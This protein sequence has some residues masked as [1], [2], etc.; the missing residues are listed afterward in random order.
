MHNC[1][2]C[3]NLVADGLKNC[4]HCNIEQ[5]PIIPNK[6][7]H[8]PNIKIYTT[9]N[10]PS[11]TLTEWLL[12]DKHQ[13]NSAILIIRAVFYIAL[14][15]LS[16]KLLTTSV[17]DMADSVWFL[18]AINTPFHEAGH[19]IFSPF[20]Q[21]IHSLGGTLGQI[22]M[23]FIC[24]ISLLKTNRDSFGASIALWWM[25]EN[26]LDISPYINDARALD[27]PLLG[28][29]VGHSSPYGFHDWEYL[30]TEANIIEYDTIIAKIAFFTGSIII[31]LALFW[32]GLILFKHY[33]RINT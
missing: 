25:G 29:N 13:D 3:Q 27:L 20:G 24:V 28:G 12:F 8:H 19:V 11:Y 10:T 4:P 14:L 7:Y 26:F 31:L 16:I 5:P 22:L 1:H 21:Y 30:L 2:N 15:M 17:E 6:E 32:A 9:E 18:H 23:P 33:Q